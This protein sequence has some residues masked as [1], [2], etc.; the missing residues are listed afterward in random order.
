MADWFIAT[1]EVP[2]DFAQ[3]ILHASALASQLDTLQAMHLRL[4]D[5]GR[6][7]ERQGVLDI[8][9]GENYAQAALGY[10]RPAEATGK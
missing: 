1:K 5:K 2:D 10:L 8:S 7:L 6:E 4:A 3:Q 9:V